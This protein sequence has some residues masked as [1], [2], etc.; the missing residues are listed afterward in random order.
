MIGA[1]CQDG[2]LTDNPLTIQALQFFQQT[3]IGPAMPLPGIPD[4]YPM[5]A[6]LAGVP[7]P[8][9]SQGPP[10]EQGPP[11]D[12][13]GCL[14][15]FADVVT[16]SG[17]S[18]LP[19]SLFQLFAENTQLVGPLN[20]DALTPTVVAMDTVDLTNMS[21]YMVTECADTFFPEPILVCNA[22]VP[23]SFETVIP[24]DET[25]RY[26]LTTTC[27]GDNPLATVVEFITTDTCGNTEE[28]PNTEQNT[29]LSTPVF[30]YTDPTSGHVYSQADWFT[31]VMAK[32]DSLLKCCPPCDKGPTYQDTFGMDPPAP[33]VQLYGQWTIASSRVNPGGGIDEVDITLLGTQTAIDTTLAPP[34]VGKYGRFW[35]LYDCNVVGPP[36]FINF[37]EQRFHA[38]SGNIVGFA[39]HL[40]Y[41]VSVT[42]GI[43]DSPRPGFG[44]W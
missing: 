14:T 30:T 35:W 43:K 20:A 3:D 25:P 40:N 19:S 41:G 12:C 42:F 13:S 33:N 9:D 4:G 36:I 16:A 34:D 15:D 39:W 44:Q 2:T 6:P 7:N 17:V 32:L 28:S 10:G 29:V 5:P 1:S 21:N 38:D 31:Q 11:G 8:C 22:T 27:T 24:E 26:Q 23:T 18:G 37:P